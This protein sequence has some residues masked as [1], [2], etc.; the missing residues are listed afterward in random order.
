[1]LYTGIDYHKRYSVV[2]TVDAEGQRVQSARIDQ[3]E[4]AAFAAYFQRLPAVALAKAGGDPARWIASS[5][6]SWAP[7][8][9][10]AYFAVTVTATE[11]SPALLVK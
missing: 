10:K 9:N 7:R 3:N 2:C 8:N 6:T 4:P 1:M 5:P 11:L